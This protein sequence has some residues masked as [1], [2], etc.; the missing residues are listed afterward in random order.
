MI[1]LFRKLN[2][3]RILALVLLAFIFITAVA[4]GEILLDAY[5]TTAK[6]EGGFSEF[7]DTVETSY[8]SK[9]KN[10]TDYINL[11]GLFARY[12][13]RKI[14]NGVATLN[15]G[16]LTNDSIPEVDVELAVKSIGRLGKDL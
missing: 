5:K 1:K 6:K 16:M 3:L 7:I 14:Y 10:K 13:G 2:G 9:I 15:N 12:S 11:N 8:T 4:N